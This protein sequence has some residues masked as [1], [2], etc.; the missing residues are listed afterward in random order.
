MNLD[1]PAWI[2]D[3]RIRRSGECAGE[4]I[5]RIV[6]ACNGL[7]LDD[8]ADQL[9]DLFLIN[10]PTHDRAHL[11]STWKTNC[12]TFYRQCLAL[13]G[14]ISPEVIEP[15][16]CGQAMANVQNAA[17]ETG[18]IRWAGEWRAVRPGWGLLYFSTGNDAHV[19]IALG[20]PDKLGVCEHGGGGR[21]RNA[22]TVQ[23]GSILSSRARP[24][25]TI[26]D[27]EA[28]CILPATGDDPY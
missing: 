27:P 28:L 11:I 18:A 14:C 24:L 17:S 2:D 10:E 21:P 15:Y 20:T 23:T 1:L 26:F 19:E 5:A 6:R 12:A 13:A 16:V 22:I 3:L 25:R 4:Q 9:A 7:S 8:N